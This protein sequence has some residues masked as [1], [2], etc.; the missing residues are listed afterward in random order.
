LQCRKQDAA[1]SGFICKI[2]QLFSIGLCKD[3][4]LVLDPPE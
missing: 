2:H 4:R 3:R 1:G